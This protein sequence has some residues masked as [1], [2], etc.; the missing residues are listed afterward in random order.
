MLLG[1]ERKNWG[2]KRERGKHIAHSGLEKESKAY[3]NSN[4]IRNKSLDR[5]L[6]HVHRFGG[7][8]RFVRRFRD[9]D[10]FIDAEDQARCFARGCNRVDLH[11]RWFPNGRSEIIADVFTRD[12]H[13][14]PDT[15]CS[16]RN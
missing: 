10:C 11:H 14:E 15:I 6:T 5:S 16:R 13:T 2:N 4:K 7:I 8:G 12:V 3:N 1:G 9:F